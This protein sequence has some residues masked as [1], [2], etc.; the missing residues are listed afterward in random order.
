MCRVCYSDYTAARV[1]STNQMIK[2]F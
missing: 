2:W 1:M